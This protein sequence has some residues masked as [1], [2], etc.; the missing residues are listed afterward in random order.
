MKHDYRP[1]G[2]KIL[3]AGILTLLAGCSVGTAEE[4]DQKE[5]QLAIGVTYV[6]PGAYTL[7]TDSDPQNNGASGSPQCDRGTDVDYWHNAEPGTDG[8]HVGWTQPGEVMRYSLGV[9]PEAGEYDVVLRL[10]SAYVGKKVRARVIYLADK[11]MPTVVQADLT[12]QTGGWGVFGDAVL[13]NGLYL[14]PGIPYALEV[15]H[16][17]GELD[18]NGFELRPTVETERFEAENYFVYGDN[19]FEDSGNSP[20]CTRYNSVDLEVTSDPKGGECNVGWGEAGEWLS[21]YIYPSQSGDYKVVARAASYV[22]GKFYVDGVYDGATGQPTSSPEMTVST[23]GW[24]N[25]TDVTLFESVRLINGPSKPHPWTL[26]ITQSGVNLNY[27]ELIPLYLCE[28]WSC[29]E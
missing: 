26:H 24:Q 27:I 5:S 10:G 8:C 12:A 7:H 4:L 1:W 18:F 11:G 14:S 28:T 13:A 6:S 15:E 16:L 29:Q 2:A 9:V 25:W 17:T 22:G 3:A 19:T 20:E 21:W 23:G